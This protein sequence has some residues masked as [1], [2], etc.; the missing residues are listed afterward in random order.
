MLVTRDN[1]AQCMEY[2]E[3]WSRL[4]VDTE[5]TGLR[6]W[7][8]DYIVGYSITTPKLDTFY[9]PVR[10]DPSILGWDGKYNLT[11]E[12]H[13]HIRKLLSQQRRSYTGWNYKFDM[14]MMLKE[15][16]PLPERC[17]DVMLAAHLINENEPNFK[18]KPTAA[19]YIDPDAET[20][21]ADLLMKLADMGLDKGGLRYLHPKD[22]APYACQDGVLTEQLRHM[23]LKPLRDWNLANLWHEV[24]DYLLATT[25][26]EQRGLLLDQDLT[27]QYAQEA[28]RMARKAMKIVRKHAGY[29]INTNSPKQLQAW[30]GVKTTKREYL[31]EFGEGH[32]EIDALLNFRAWDRANSAYYHAYMH[33]VDAEG[34][35]HANLNLMGT[36]TG[37]P[38]ASNPNMQAVPRYN[39]IYKVKDVF[40]A[41][42]GHIM[43]SADYSQAELRLGAHYAR[44]TIM[45]RILN[46]GGDIHQATATE[47][48]IERDAAKRINFGVF[49]GIGALKLARNLRIPVPLAKQYLDAYHAKFSNI[50]PLYRFMQNTAS[51]QGYIRLWTGRVR[52]YNMIDA[53]VHKALSNLIQGGV[54]EMMRK[55]IT[56]LDKE[57][58]LG[59]FHMQ[60]QVHDNII[61]EIPEENRKLI[62]DIKREMERFPQ[63][64]F[65]PPKVDIKVGDRWGQLKDWTPNTKSGGARAA[66]SKR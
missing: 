12:Q 44:E 66:K 52:R 58:Q 29:D 42:P 35:V 54:G 31:E 22:A 15:N 14:E 37:R 55:K 20:E 17:E 36:V 63:F 28:E 49:Y 53:P 57:V 16:I 11:E 40:L 13:Q 27:I 59:N 61:F 33:H 26:M 62:P 65:T 50:R 39:S 64:R 4:I 10:H 32:P 6:M 7:H 43:M 9:F 56:K 38:S 23:Y 45:A 21:E 34:L 30:L 5:T 19:R 24:N 51:L 48:E 8:E 18:L 3:D 47:L 25:R 1:F 41:R 46:Q 60:L 2:L